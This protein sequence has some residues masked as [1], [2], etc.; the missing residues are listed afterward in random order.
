M[1]AQRTCPECG[2]AVPEGLVFCEDCG[3]VF[4]GSP[5]ASK[6]VVRPSRPRAKPREARSLTL[7]GLWFGAAVWGGLS[8]LVLIWAL[9]MC[10][11]LLSA[12][13]FMAMVGAALGYGVAKTTPSDIV[14]TLVGV[15]T[16]VVAGAVLGFMAEECAGDT[17]PGGLVAKVGP[18]VGA[19]I[20]GLSGHWLAERL[21]GEA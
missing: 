18:L 8:F 1:V 5:P 7:E 11:I 16:G 13:A 21:Y 20:G 12:A 14:S 9:A 6:P 3:A 10:P 15:V 2:A 19:V 17:V 4:I